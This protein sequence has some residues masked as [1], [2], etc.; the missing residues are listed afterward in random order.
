MQALPPK[1]FDLKASELRLFATLSSILQAPQGALVLGLISTGLSL[2][3]LS[4][5]LKNHDLILALKKPAKL[6]VATLLRLAY[7]RELNI[8]ILNRHA[9]Y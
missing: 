4:S 5:I 2:T 7:A 6:S 9:I 1:F 3:G 8:V